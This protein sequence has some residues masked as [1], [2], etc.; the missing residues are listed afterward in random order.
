MGWTQP[1]MGYES[2]TKITEGDMLKTFD[3][4][5]AIDLQ[6][7][8]DAVT[9]DKEHIQQMS[10]TN[11]KTMKPKVVKDQ[12]RWSCKDNS[13]MHSVITNRVQ[14]RR[15]QAMYMWFYWLRFCDKQYQFR[16][17]WR[18]GNKNLADYWT[19]HRHYHLPHIIWICTENSS[20]H[21]ITWNHL[22]LLHRRRQKAERDMELVQAIP[23]C[24]PATRVF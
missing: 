9:A 11:G 19:K 23:D 20:H 10:A 6:V 7:V 2:T 1:V 5:T 24:L 14:P 22:E 18:L 13:A 16:Y 17:Y 8:P 21:R 4:L 3:L 12:T 15:T